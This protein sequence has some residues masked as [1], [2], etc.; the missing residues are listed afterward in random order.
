MDAKC[1]T[2]L[3]K[4][5]S[6]NRMVN[7]QCYRIAH[8]HSTASCISLYNHTIDRERETVF[9]PLSLHTFVMSAI[10][11]AVLNRSTIPIC[12]KQVTRKKLK[13]CLTPRCTAAIIQD[14]YVFRFTIKAKHQT[15]RIDNRVINEN[16]CIS[17]V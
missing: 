14:I 6:R 8:T 12:H 5:C 10:C 2:S 3:K 15:K 4:L 1:Q 11:L 17:G 7:V 13:S 9:I 16:A